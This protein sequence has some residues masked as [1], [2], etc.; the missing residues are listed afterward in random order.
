MEQRSYGKSLRG[1][2]T[3]RT[4]FIGLVPVLLVGAFA[5]F[6]LTQLT[7]N[8]NRQLELS[9]GRVARLGGRQ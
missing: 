1:K 4:L 3:N 5:W 8:A 6:S 2:I 9:R 7:S